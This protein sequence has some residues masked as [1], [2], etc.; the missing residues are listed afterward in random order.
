MGLAFPAASVQSELVCKGLTAAE[1]SLW[2]M[3]GMAGRRQPCFTCIC[4]PRADR[5]GLLVRAGGQGS[6][7]H[8][9]RLCHGPRSAQHAQEPV[10]WQ[11]RAVPQ[12][13]PGGW[14]GAA[15]V[16]PQRQ[17]L[18]SVRPRGGGEERPRG[19][20]CL[21]LSPIMGHTAAPTIYSRYHLA[22]TALQMLAAKMGCFCSR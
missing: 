15:Q 3:A 22:P 12:D 14:R 5:P 19:A 13:G 16:H 11:G 20:G 7:C 1:M 18:R 10:P 4:R 9:C 2:G 17:L 21:G 8:R 6:V